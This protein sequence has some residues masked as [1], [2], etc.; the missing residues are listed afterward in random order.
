MPGPPAEDA[1]PA[2]TDGFV[3][4]L[5]SGLGSLV[6]LAGGVILGALI[7]YYLLKDGSRLRARSSRRSTLRSE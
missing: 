7:M 1:A 2:V 6:G 3:A 4:K 5:V